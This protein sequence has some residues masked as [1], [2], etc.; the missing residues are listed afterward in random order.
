MPYFFD[1]NF[2]LLSVTATRLLEVQSTDSM[3]V[4]VYLNNE[5]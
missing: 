5:P 4:V 3:V 2:F 1:S